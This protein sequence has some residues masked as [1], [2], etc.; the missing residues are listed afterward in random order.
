MKLS[1]LP[2]KYPRLKYAVLLLW[3]VMALLVTRGRISHDAINNFLIFKYTYFHA[4]NGQNLYDLYPANYYDSNHYGPLFSLVIAPFAL[5][6][7]GIDMYAWQVCM[8]LI[9]FAAVNKLPIRVKEKLFLMVICSQELHISLLEFQT[10]SAVAAMIMLT[11][12]CI[13]NKKDFWAALFIVAGFYIK[14]YGIV[15]LA[16]F[17]FSDNKKVLVQSLI[18]WGAA[19][20]VAPMAIFS[21]SF[22]VQSYND[23]YHSLVFKNLQNEAI[24]NPYQDISVMGMIRK[25]S[26]N[27]EIPTLPVLLAGMFLFSLPYLRVDRLSN[28]PFRLMMLSS[29]LLFT[30]LFS[31]GSEHATYIVAFAGIGIW[32]VTLKRSWD[33]WQWAFFLVVMYFGSLFYS[34]L[35]TYHFRAQIM[36]PYALKALPCLLV[37]LA[38]SAQLI[39]GQVCFRFTPRYFQFVNTLKSNKIYEGQSR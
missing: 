13:E 16:F 21:P 26:G 38:I 27:G 28:R 1:E 7:K 37:W 4:L 17:F 24:T 29:V 23:W 36:R 8:V 11:W 15:G 32:F 6:P 30:V 33:K 3:I 20:F 39:R 25:I 34:D 31:T 10:N 2:E 12:I 14:L 18:F 35:S 22:V 19:L 9:F 5:L